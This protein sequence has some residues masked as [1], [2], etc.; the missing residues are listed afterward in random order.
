[1]HQLEEREAQHLA[2]LETFQQKLTDLEKYAKK[3]SQ[4][5]EK[6]Q[7]KVKKMTDQ[8]QESQHALDEL[9]NHPELRHKQ[10]PKKKSVRF[11]ANFLDS[12]SITDLQE[13]VSTLENINEALEASLKVEPTVRCEITVPGSPNCIRSRNRKVQKKATRIR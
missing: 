7:S 3:Q 8:L 6:S 2:Q 5:L 10:E 1:V 11:A 13:K 4:D 12:S 9:R